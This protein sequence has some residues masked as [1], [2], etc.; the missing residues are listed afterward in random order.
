MTKR[1]TADDYRREL[2]SLKLEQLAMEKR[3]RARAKN[4][5][6]QYP[7]IWVTLGSNCNANK[8]ADFINVPLIHINTALSLI[9]VIEK[10]LADTHPHKQTTITF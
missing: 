4:L 7:E 10:H 5:C 1:L 8:T 2:H 3:I 9:E 6:K